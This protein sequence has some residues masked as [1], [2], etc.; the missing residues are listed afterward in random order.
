MVA[1][2]LVTSM[3]AVPAWSGDA[4]PDA[5]VKY[6]K[7]AMSA[8]S[9][10]MKSLKMLASGEIVRPGDVAAHADALAAGARDMVSLYPSGTGVDS[11]LKTDAKAE[12]WSKSADF[13]AEAKKFA[14]ATTKLAELA[15]GGDMKALAAQ[16]ETVGD[17][18]KSCHDGFKAKH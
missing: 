17:S 15:K 18:C 2:A 16:L 12:I 6:R 9:K 13:A 7:A 11:G 14:E 3:L 5:M 8:T 1:V 4:S 10:H